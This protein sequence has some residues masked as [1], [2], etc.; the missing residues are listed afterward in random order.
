M[1]GGGGGEGGG[2]IEEDVEEKI[3]PIFPLSLHVCGLANQQ[4]FKTVPYNFSFIIPVLLLISDPFIH[5]CIHS[6]LLIHS[7]RTPTVWQSLLDNGGD[8]REQ[9]TDRVP[10]LQELSGVRE[11]EILST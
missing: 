3:N 11:R 9:K 1:G 6:F 2:G 5:G 7:F 4:I 10:G 8:N